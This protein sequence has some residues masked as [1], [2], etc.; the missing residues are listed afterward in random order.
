VEHSD[1][2]LASVIAEEASGMDWAARIHEVIV[3]YPREWQLALLGSAM[4]YTQA[5]IGDALG[6]DQ[7]IVSTLL[8]LVR[9]RFVPAIMCLN[10]TRRHAEAALGQYP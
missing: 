1:S 4:Q 3:E 9:S 6:M 10:S 7:R 5:Q 8:S 2:V